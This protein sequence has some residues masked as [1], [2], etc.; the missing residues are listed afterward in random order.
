MKWHFSAEANLHFMCQ[1][2]QLVA[3]PMRKFHRSR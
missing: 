1:K 3:K 2:K